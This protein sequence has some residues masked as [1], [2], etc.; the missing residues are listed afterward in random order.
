MNIKISGYFEN[1]AKERG[2]DMEQ[3]KG[4]I[5]TSTERYY[6]HDS[7]RMIRVGHHFNELV[8][9]PYDQE[10]DDLTIITAHQTTRQQINARLNEGRLEYA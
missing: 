8:M 4:I 6:D 9:I 1:K 5:K 10:G 2:F 7:G 3:L